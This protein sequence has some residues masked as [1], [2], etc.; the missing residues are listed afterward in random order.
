MTAHT[1]YVPGP[2]RRMVTLFLLC[3]CWAVP[4]LR[5]QQAVAVT[6]VRVMGIVINGNKKTREPI[7]L[8]E[9]L[10][11][12]GDTLTSTAFYERLERSRQNLM[13]TGLFN[14]VQ[15]LPLYVSPA[16][17]LVEVTVNE[18]WYLWPA[19]VFDLADPNFNTW[20]LTR[21]LG[22][23]NYGLYLYQ[24]NF[25]GRNETVYAKVQLGYTQQYAPRYRVPYLD[26]N[27]RWG[28][29]VGGSFF[30]QAEVTAGTVDNKRILVRNPDGSNRDEW[31]ADLEATLRRTH[32][33][34]HSWRLGY[35]RATVADTIV[36]TALDYFHGDATTT[37]FLTFGY[38]VVW[39][40]RDVRIFP[41]QG[42]FAEVRLDRHGLGL[43]DEHAPDITT[44][45]AT[46][47]NWWKVHERWTLALSLRGKGT[48][49]TPPYYVQEGL[50]YRSAVRGY[51]YYVVD[52]EHYAMGKANVIFQLVAPRTYRVEAI[53]L[54]AFRTLHFALYLDLFA[55]AGHVWDARYASANPLANT[56]LGGTGVGLDLVTSYDQ[57]VRAEYTLNGL[58]EHGFFLHFTQPF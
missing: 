29:S 52:G 44:V 17:A 18:R 2:W 51:E 7:I 55:D 25:R 57:V 31:K 24:Y 48:F 40:R 42:H 6:H 28:M 12:T 4:H 8:R 11:R 54:E 20:W 14:T 33:I 58:G 34:R 26:R 56:W 39:D 27:Q 22:R 41:R 9:M 35:T 3:C 13:N 30:Q 53:P 15:L 19:V 46:A 50:G 45:Y 5:A 47:K 1:G 36:R 23:V 49:G 43:L 16:E 37:Q 10:V 38:S 21:D 32:D